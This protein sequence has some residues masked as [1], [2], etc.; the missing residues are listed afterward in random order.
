MEANVIEMISNIMEY[1]NADLS[2]YKPSSDVR[3]TAIG[4]G[5]EAYIKDALADSF[6]ASIEERLQRYKKAF[7]WQGNQV[8]PPDLTVWEKLGGDAFE[9]K[10]MKSAMADLELNSSYPRDYLYSEDKMISGGCREAEN[11]SKKDMFYIIGHVPSSKIKCLTLIHGSCYA[12]SR[13]TYERPRKLV[14]DGL[15]GGMH[16]IEFAQTREMGRIN[17]V[18]PLRITDLRLRGMWMIRNPL[19]LFREFFGYNPA[20]ESKEFSLFA[21]ISAAKYSSFSRASRRKAE[22]EKALKIKD[23]RVTDPNNISK[24]INAKLIIGGW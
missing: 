23:I 9:I 8:N 22:S 13:E 21:I 18:D 12:A 2:R 5:M 15:K 7:S 10:K 1:H 11:W 4:E 14:R 19:V 16:G 24:G 6:G 17:G 3:I 20:Q